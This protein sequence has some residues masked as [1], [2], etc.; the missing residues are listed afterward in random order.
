[1]VF[2][3]IRIIEVPLN[4]EGAL[5]AIEKIKET[6]G[7][8][9]VVGA[10]TVT[11]PQRLK[12]AVA[13]GVDFCLAPN[14]NEDVVRSAAKREVEFI[15]GVFTPSEAFRAIDLGSKSLKIFPFDQFGFKAIGALRQVL[16]DSVN[17]IGVGGLEVGD[18]A[19]ALSK[20]LD[21]IG[22][23]SSLYKPEMTPFELNTYLEE[24]LGKG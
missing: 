5:K 17:L 12:E 24:E 23:G 6:H 20:G 16:P 7:D 2:H 8:S 3:G 14:L 10:G 4:R 11:T 18:L 19:L 21:G 9:A 1:L 22:I 13:A 15:P